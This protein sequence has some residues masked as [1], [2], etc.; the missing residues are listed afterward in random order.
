MVISEGYTGGDKVG[1]PCCHAAW[2]ISS[3]VFATQSQQNYGFGKYKCEGPCKVI[4]EINQ[5]K[6]KKA[7]AVVVNEN[8]MKV[9]PEGK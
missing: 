6:L 1:T 2:W 4:V 5:A 9:E 7:F 3:L 8:A